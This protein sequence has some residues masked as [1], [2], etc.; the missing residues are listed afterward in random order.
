MIALGLFD[1]KGFTD[2]KPIIEFGSPMFN[3]AEILL[4]NEKKL[5]I[6]ARNNSK[7]NMYVQ[8]ATFNGKPLQ[9]CWMYRDELMKGGILI[10]TMGNQPNKTWGT[11]TPPP[12]VQ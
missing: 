1:V 3:K 2:E 12:S 10:F 9:N 7:E 4:G 5:V 11:Q 6:E 8:S